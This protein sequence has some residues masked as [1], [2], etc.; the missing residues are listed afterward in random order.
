MGNEL[1]IS[2]LTPVQIFV[3]RIVAEYLSKTGHLGFIYD[4]ILDYYDKI[5]G[6]RYYSK[7]S[8]DRELRRLSEL[9]YFTRYQ[10]KIRRE[11]GR[12]WTTKFIPTENFYKLVERHFK[13]KLNK[14]VGLKV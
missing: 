11:T 10:I 2:G 1:E 6:E 12:R 4:D 3:L 8:I 7:N 5:H 9:G 13:L 14:P